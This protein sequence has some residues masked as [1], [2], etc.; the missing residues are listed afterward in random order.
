[1]ESAWG[2]V[3]K[4]GAGMLEGGDRV[5]G[6]CG[7]GNDG[8]E[9]FV[10]A[11]QLGQSG[12]VVEVALLGPRDALKGDAATMAKRWEGTV[13]PLAFAALEGKAA[14]YVDA[15]FGAGLARP[16]EGAAVTAVEAMNAA[17]VPIVAV[18]VPS[19]LDGSTGIASGPV[20]RA[21]R[22]VT[23]FRR[24]PGH[25]LLPGRTLCGAVKVADLG[26]PAALP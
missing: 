14:L 9:G 2:A 1:M 13:E 4:A 25:L 8:G 17:G 23:F 10:A 12:Y 18:D 16:L 21:S 6:V 5:R 24:K 7:G 20:V 22:T 19:G 11:R 3:G 15:L 26:I